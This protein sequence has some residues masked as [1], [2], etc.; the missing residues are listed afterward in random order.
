MN[1]IVDILLYVCD[2]TQLKLYIQSIC[3]KKASI[4]TIKDKRIKEKKKEIKKLSEK[5]LHNNKTKNCEYV[6]IEYNDGS[7][8]VGKKMW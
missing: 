4:E 7:T 3:N 2:F 5:T 6:S 8:I 1:V